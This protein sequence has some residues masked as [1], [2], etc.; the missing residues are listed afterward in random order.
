MKHLCNDTL[1]CKF[2]RCSSLETC[3]G[4]CSIS[5]YV[6]PNS[7]VKQFHMPRDHAYDMKVKTKMMIGDSDIGLGSDGISPPFSSCFFHEVLRSS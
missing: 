2:K 6:K 4:C 5:Y 1:Y 3:Q 7:Q